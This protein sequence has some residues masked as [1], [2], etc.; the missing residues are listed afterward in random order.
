MGVN[1]VKGYIWKLELGEIDNGLSWQLFY[2]F[3][4]RED[5]EIIKVRIVYDLVVRYGGVSFNDIMLFG[6]KLQ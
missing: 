4:V 3:V 5:K 6:L 2:F 1:E